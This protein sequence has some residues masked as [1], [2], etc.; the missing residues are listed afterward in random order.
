[1]GEY[2][3]ALNVRFGSGADAQPGW[4]EI[5]EIESAYGQKRTFTDKENLA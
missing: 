2:S 1:M 5:K 3:P 4:P